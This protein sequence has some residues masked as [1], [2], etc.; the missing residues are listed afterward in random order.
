VDEINEDLPW[1]AE[2]ASPLKGMQVP[3]EESAVIAQ[4][5]NAQLSETLTASWGDVSQ[6]D[7]ELVRT[8]PET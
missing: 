7:S 5:H 8:G 3:M 4:W 6:S 2:T 1:V